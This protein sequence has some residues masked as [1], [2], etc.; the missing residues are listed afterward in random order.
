MEPSPDESHR[1]S[2]PNV[3]ATS[4]AEAPRDVA[5]GRSKLKS[6][7]RREAGR[8][9]FSAV[10]DCCGPGSSVVTSS[11]TKEAADELGLAA[12][13]DVVVIVKASDVLLAVE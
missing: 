7:W 4:T 9:H 11:I 5:R 3:A 13:N 2:C 6:L 8:R 1:R 10:I 12:G